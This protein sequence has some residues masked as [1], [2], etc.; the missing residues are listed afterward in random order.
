MNY[1]VQLI[2]KVSLFNDLFGIICNII[3]V[4][5]K[6]WYMYCSQKVKPMR[7]YSEVNVH[8]NVIYE[9]TVV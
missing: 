4:T 2:E 3:A 5:L 6:V 9:A 8:D 1:D 7:L